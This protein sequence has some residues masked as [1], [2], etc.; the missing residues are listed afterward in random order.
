MWL[1]SLVVALM[2]VGGSS[3]G[4]Q[5]YITARAVYLRGSPSKTGAKLRE[6]EQG[7]TVTRRSEVAAKPGW[8]PVRTVDGKAGWVG[9][10]HLRNLEIAAAA[11]ATGVE[12][13][14][15]DAAFT[16]IDTSWTKPAIVRSTIL[17]R[18][19]IMSCGATGDASDD[20]GTNL[21]KNRADI[22]DSTHLVTVDAIR[23]LPDTALWRF[24][25]RRHWT[26]ADSL[27]VIPYEGIPVTV[28]G[29]FEVVKPQKTS[30]PTRGHTVGE[31]P[32]CHSWSEDDTDWH[33]AL[34]ADPSEPEERSV[35]VEPTPR[36]KRHQAAWLASTVSQLAG[37]HSPN[38]PRD[39]ANAARVRVTGFL[40][41]DPV[42]PT[43][44][45]GHCTTGCA[46][47]RFFRATLWEVHPVTRIEV[48][49]NGQWVELREP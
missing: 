17:V 26:A 36:T 20:D 14:V 48:F 13:D 28:E 31:A 24:T 12:T 27:L 47:Q 5:T 19:G 45:R 6:L 46:N 3:V 18:G 16:R 41:L 7:D 1:G 29:F 49:R 39:E 10:V 35:V 25:N 4:A 44:I 21:H 15:G 9:I 11:A 42:H 22:P 23:S 2:L 43:H 38:G 8:L 40:L 32:N 37:R 33:V 34:V 30:A